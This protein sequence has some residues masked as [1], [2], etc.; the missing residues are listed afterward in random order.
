[1]NDTP[2]LSDLQYV[3]L[4]CRAPIREVATHT[5]MNTTKVLEELARTPVPPEIKGITI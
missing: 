3:T 4:M 1:M 5:G 2:R